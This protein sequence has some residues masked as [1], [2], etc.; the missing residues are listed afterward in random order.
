MPYLGRTPAGAAGNTLAAVYGDY[1][2]YNAVNDG[3]PTLRLGSAAGESLGI[4]VAYNS[5]AQTLDKVTFDTAT[6]SGTGHD[7]QYIFNVD[8]TN[9]MSI[10]DDGIIAWI[11]D[12]VGTYGPVTVL[13]SDGGE[14]GATSASET[15]TILVDY[16]YLV[17][18]F[19]FSVFK[20]PQSE[21]K[22][23]ALS[24][25]KP[26]EQKSDYL[27]YKINELIKNN[28]TFSK[29]AFLFVKLGGLARISDIILSNYE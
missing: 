28:N 18:D 16:D 14:D 25:G 11:P 7:G 17:I 15:F 19:N 22:K 4:T 9:R 2:L 1:T 29:N 13:V 6:S 21:D 3:N 10:T 24:I 5:G 26:I 23:I 27:I 20:Y 12:V 8:G